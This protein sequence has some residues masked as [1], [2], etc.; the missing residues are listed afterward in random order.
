MTVLISWP[1]RGYHLHSRALTPALAAVLAGGL[2]QE[3]LGRCI[4]GSMHSLRWLLL[5][6]AIALIGSACA[7]SDARPPANLEA[8]AASLYQ[9]YGAALAAGRRGALAAFY[10]NEGALTVLNGVARRQSGEELNRYYL[11][12]W[13]PPTY[14][15]WEDMAF[16]SI[17]PSQ[18]LVTGG[19]RWQDSGEKDTTRYI[20]AALLVVVDSG[21]AIVFEHETQ[22]PQQ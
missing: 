6:L 19:F 7:P 1:F 13:T 4:R 12:A 16:D 5:L 18:V 17:A 15:A 2:L 20:Y 10:H 22:R 3:E 21:L 14:F 8:S 11:G 9:Q